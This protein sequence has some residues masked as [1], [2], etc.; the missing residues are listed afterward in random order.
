MLVR[1]QQL[2]SFQ[3]FLLFKWHCFIK[4]N[5][6]WYKHKT[7]PNFNNNIVGYRNLK[8]THERGHNFGKN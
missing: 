3:S 2:C 8:G 6:C 4:C 1:T 5:L 7:C